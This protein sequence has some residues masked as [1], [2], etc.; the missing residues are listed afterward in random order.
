MV[1]QGLHLGTIAELPFHQHVAQKKQMLIWQKKAPSRYDVKFNFEHLNCF[2]SPKYQKKEE[3]YVIH[4]ITCQIWDTD[5]NTNHLPIKLITNYF[6]CICA[7][8]HMLLN[9][10]W[11]YLAWLTLQL[12]SIICIDIIHCDFSL[13]IKFGD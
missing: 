3:A 1:L 10:I 11:F 5:L 13:I 4:S 7:N 9:I 12:L 8:Q 6:Q 2:Y